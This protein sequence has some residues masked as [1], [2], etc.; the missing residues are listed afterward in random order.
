MMVIVFFGLIICLIY[1][2]FNLINY[3]INLV[4]D[5]IFIIVILLIII[6]LRFF[7]ILKVKVIEVKVVFEDLDKKRKIILLNYEFFNIVF[8]YNI[9]NLINGKVYIGSVI[10]GKVISLLRVYLISDNKG[11]VL[12]RYFVLKYGINNFV[13]ILLEILIIKMIGKY[14][15]KFI[16]L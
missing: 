12:L 9:I 16:V 14:N 1:L 6:L 13:F 8:I 11:N 10:I 2:D 15:K 5:V 4:Y 3:D 7:I